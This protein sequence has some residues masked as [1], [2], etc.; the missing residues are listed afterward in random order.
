MYK[1][2]FVGPGEHDDVV[3][4][5]DCTPAFTA[6]VGFK[7]SSFFVQIFNFEAAQIEDFALGTNVEKNSVDL[8]TFLAAI[9]RA[10]SLLS[11]QVTRPEGGG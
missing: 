9:D 11:Y 10:K 3:V 1:I 8:E 6:V 2:A 7:N 4:E 5:I